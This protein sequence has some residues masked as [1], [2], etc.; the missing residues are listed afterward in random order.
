M[1][2]KFSENFCKDAITTL[3]LKLF[4]ISSIFS[5]WFG[6][7]LPAYTAHKEYIELQRFN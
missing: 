5:A 2:P 6:C 7:F 3:K 1:I 4:R